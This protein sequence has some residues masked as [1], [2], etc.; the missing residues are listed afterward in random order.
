M[1]NLNN[2]YF[3]L[4]RW[5]YLLA[6]VT[7]KEYSVVCTVL[8]IITPLKEGVYSIRTSK[9]QIGLPVFLVVSNE[10]KVNHEGRPTA[11]T[12]DCRLWLRDAEVKL[13][14]HDKAHLNVSGISLA[15]LVILHITMT[16][17]SLTRD[18][19]MGL[20]VSR[21]KPTVVLSTNHDGCNCGS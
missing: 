15:R 18:R 4:I 7:L 5:M 21:D 3:P 2:Q 12:H 19:Y 6:C 20:H 1:L 10:A 13:K 8:T 16:N 11:V 17:N 9:K 14:L